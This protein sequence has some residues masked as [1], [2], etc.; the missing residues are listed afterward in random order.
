MSAYETF[1][2]QRLGLRMMVVLGIPFAAVGTWLLLSSGW[3]LWS[4]REVRSWREVPAR[5]LS[6]ELV[7]YSST[8][9]N[10]RSSESMEAK[11][12]YDY[13]VDDVRYVGDRVGLSTGGDGVDG[14]AS[15]VVGGLKEAQR[16]GRTVPA[17]VDPEDPSRA[18]LR[19]EVRWN[20]LAFRAGVGAIFA[21]VGLGL[22]VASRLI[23]RRLL[24]PW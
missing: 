19:R 10:G 23:L 3:V 15:R 16:E 22:I 12:S 18:I 21:L 1:R 2:A 7:V 8:S 6:A 13:V 24:H 14:W 11:A 5:I 17:W 20:L 9:R 4:A